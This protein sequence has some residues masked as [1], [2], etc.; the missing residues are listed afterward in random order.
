MQYVVNFDWL[1]MRR[2]AGLEASVDLD[3]SQWGADAVFVGNTDVAVET[4]RRKQNVYLPSF[5]FCQLAQ[6]FLKIL[7][8]FAVAVYRHWS[9]LYSLIWYIC[10]L[11]LLP[12]IHTGAHN[13]F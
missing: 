12:N 4:C 6:H 2:L 1:E 3:H 7:I 11:F 5:D 8:G 13:L 9:Y 10:T